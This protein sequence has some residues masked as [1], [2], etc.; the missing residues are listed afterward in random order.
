MNTIKCRNCHQWTDNDKPQCLYCGY[1][2]HHEI[3]REREILKKPLQTGFPFIKIGK[4][5][6]WPIKAGKSIIF[7]FQ[8]IVYGI[9]SLIM[10]I[11]S[12]VVH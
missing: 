3:K 12:S 4:S 8:L 2:H 7:F 10:Y 1:E 6:T 9:V 11:A 5:D